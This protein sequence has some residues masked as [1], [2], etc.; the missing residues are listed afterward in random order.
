M[1]NWLLYSSGWF[2]AQPGACI[3]LRGLSCNKANWRRPMRMMPA[4]SNRCC[5]RS[6][7]RSH[8]VTA[9]APMSDG[10]STGFW[11]IRRWDKAC[12][13]KRLSCPED[14]AQIVKENHT[15]VGTYWLAHLRLNYQVQRSVGKS[16]NNKVAII[17]GPSSRPRWH[18]LNASSDLI[19]RA[20]NGS[21]LKWW[22]KSAVSFY[23]IL[24]THLAPIL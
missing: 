1:V 4:S 14:D 8:V 13:S 15:W 21:D 12:P 16:G 7:R 22:S 9:M 3:I 11:R 19:S 6:I 20:G 23:S 2:H 18:G 10:M 17:V 5:A 24:M